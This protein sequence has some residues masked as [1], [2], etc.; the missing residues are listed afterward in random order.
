MSMISADSARKIAIEYLSKLELKN[1]EPLQLADNE[2]LEKAYGWIYFYNSKKYL[3][4]GDF[5]HMLAGNAPFIVE[6][7]SGNIHV[8]GTDKPIEDYIAEY[9]KTV[10]NGRDSSTL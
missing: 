9:E 2:T 7:N 4:T 8:T 10:A 5:R 3:E 6:K 1:R